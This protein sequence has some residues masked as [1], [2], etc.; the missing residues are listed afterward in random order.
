MVLERFTKFVEQIRSA[1]PAQRGGGSSAGSKAGAPREP[2][3]SRATAPETRTWIESFVRP[4]PLAM[5]VV[6]GIL[7]SFTELIGPWA[8][9]G[10]LLLATAPLVYLLQRIERRLVELLQ[11][12]RDP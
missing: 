1:L 8:F 9:L 7:A 4:A 10:Y 3:E 2:R 12:R 5:L 11:Q 6:G